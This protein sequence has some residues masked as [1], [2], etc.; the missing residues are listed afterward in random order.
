MLILAGTV[1]RILWRF[2][3]VPPRM[4]GLV[5][6]FHRVAGHIVHG[7]LFVVLLV[8]PIS[9]YPLSTFAGKPP[10]LFGLWQLPALVAEDKAAENRRRGA[11]LHAVGGLRL[12]PPTRVG[13]RLSVIFTRDGVLGRMLPAAAMEPR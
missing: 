6:A 7:L 2:V 13:R 11:R 9:G 10:V 3:D 12:D 1:L 8:M 4:S 5:G